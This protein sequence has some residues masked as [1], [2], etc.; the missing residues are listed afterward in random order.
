MKN[1]QKGFTLI[2]LMIVVAIIG[3]L[4]AV[5]IPNYQDY[6]AKS[7]FSAALTEAAN[8]KTGWDA[9]LLEDKTP[10]LGTDPSTGGIGVVGTNANTT[11][12]VDA[13]AGT[14]SALIVGGPSS[15]AGKNITYLRNAITGT[16]TCTTTA[17]TKYVSGGASVC[18]SV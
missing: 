16:W 5:A 3:I 4:A 6:V 18:T 9:V 14:I 2:E 10:Q 17:I 8:G 12:T 13:A 11:L 7:K 15:V 1:V